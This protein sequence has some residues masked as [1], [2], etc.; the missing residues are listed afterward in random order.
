MVTWLLSNNMDQI[1][2]YKNTDGLT[3]YKDNSHNDIINI[4]LVLLYQVLDE[5]NVTM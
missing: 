2:Q 5:R 3:N 1:Q 4:P